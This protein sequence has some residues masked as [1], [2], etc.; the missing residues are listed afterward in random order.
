MAGHKVNLYDRLGIQQDDE[1]WFAEAEWTAGG[2]SCLNTLNLTPED[3]P[4]LG[5]LGTPTCGES[6]SFAGTTLI[7]SETPHL[8]G[9][10]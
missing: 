7:I 1:R 5:A 9:R 8:G 2:A 6:S 4:C 3:A 10:L